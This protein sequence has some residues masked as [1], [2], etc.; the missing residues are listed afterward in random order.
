MQITCPCC[1]SKYTLE[2]GVNDASARRFALLMG[3]IQPAI[4]RQLPGYLAL[5]KPPVQGLRWSRMLALI[6][7][8]EPDIRRGAIERNGREWAAPAALWATAMQTVID[9]RGLKLPLKGHG[10]LY[11]IIA[12]KANQSE[13]RAEAEA[14]EAKRRPSYQRP[15]GERSG[16]PRSAADIVT[17]K[18]REQWDKELGIGKFHD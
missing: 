17:E 4:A 12:A 10:L 15:A 1:A 13:G 14:E 9:K 2:A 18:M 6:E 8:I 7:E 16:Q 3:S 11:E 5:F